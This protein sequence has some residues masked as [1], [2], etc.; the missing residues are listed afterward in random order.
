MFLD[1]IDLS[2]LAATQALATR[3]APLLGTGDV[4]A[5]SGELGTGKTEFARALVHALGVAGDVP[6]PTFTL[7]QTYETDGGLVVSHFDLYR[8]K[9]AHELDELGWDDALAGGVSL[10]EWPEKAG[11]RLPVS[12]LNIRFVLAP[13]GTRF[14]S[15]EADST[16]SNRLKKVFL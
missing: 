5:L 14:C 2:D 13:D 15:F 10:V 3:L 9:S 6:S 1:R 11:G 12:S 7:L 16:W 4:L 8:L